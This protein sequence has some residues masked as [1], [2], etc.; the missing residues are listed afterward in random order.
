MRSLEICPIDSISVSMQTNRQEQN[1]KNFPK[2]ELDLVRVL[3]S[4]FLIILGLEH[5]EIV[6]ILMTLKTKQQLG[7]MALW[8]RNNLS[9]R[10]SRTEIMDKLLMVVGYQ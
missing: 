1:L 4:E 6:G 9:H 3:L 8:V 7:E 2:D 5:K 10:P